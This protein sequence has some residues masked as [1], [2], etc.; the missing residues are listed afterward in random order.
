MRGV[1][2]PLQAMTTI[3]AGWNTSSPSASK[4]QAPVAMRSSLVSMRLTRQRVRNST[5][6]RRAS[7]Q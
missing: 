3:S 5:R 4:Y 7:C 6:L 2:M 1:P